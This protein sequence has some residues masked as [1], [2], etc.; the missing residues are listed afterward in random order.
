MKEVTFLFEIQKYWKQNHNRYNLN[1]KYGTT[2]LKINVPFFIYID[3]HTENL[4]CSGR[5]QNINR[6][7]LNC[8]ILRDEA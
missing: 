7:Q 6:E 2:E 3:A 5:Q 1:Y 4:G 8:I